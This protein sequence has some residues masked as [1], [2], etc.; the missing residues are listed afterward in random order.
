VTCGARRAPC[1][2]PQR[3]GPLQKMSKDKISTAKKKPS[4]P[5]VV[6]IG[7]FPRG[8]CPVLQAECECAA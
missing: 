4:E 5:R 2:L 6:N 1:S 7:W 8:K 3:C